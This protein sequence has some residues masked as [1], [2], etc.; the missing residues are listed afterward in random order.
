MNS[1][2]VMKNNAIANVTA[3]SH[4]LLEIDIEIYLSF[5]D[6]FAMPN[7][8]DHPWCDLHTGMRFSQRVMH[9]WGCGCPAAGPEAPWLRLSAGES[10]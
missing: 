1:E 6:S 10:R 8:C 4:I 9:T 2:T 7:E 5:D 3:V